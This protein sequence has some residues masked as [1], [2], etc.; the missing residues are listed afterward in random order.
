MEVAGDMIF[1]D[2]TSGGVR[3]E[4]ATEDYTLFKRTAGTWRR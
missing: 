2:D 1:T 4:E 3:P